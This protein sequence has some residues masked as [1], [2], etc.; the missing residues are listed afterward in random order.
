MVDNPRFPILPWTRIPNL[1]PHILNLVRRRLI[2]DWAARRDVML[3]VLIE[4]FVRNPPW[5]GA[6]HQVLDWLRIGTTQGRGRYDRYKQRDIP[7][8][9]IRIRPL[10]KNWKRILNR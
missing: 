10:G 8:K 7:G 9:D 6:V 1:G 2:E 5:S 3:P 4:T